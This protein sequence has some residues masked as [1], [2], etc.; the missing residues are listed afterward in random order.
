MEWRRLVVPSCF[1]ESEQR[2]VEGRRNQC[3]T[4]RYAEVCVSDTQGFRALFIILTKHVTIA[5]A[6]TQ[7]QHN[8][9][10]GGT[11]SSL[12]E[13]TDRQVPQNN[14]EAWR[15]NLKNNSVWFRVSVC[16][17]NRGLMLSYKVLPHPVIVFYMFTSRHILSYGF[18]SNRL[19]LKNWGLFSK[20]YLSLQDFLVPELVAWWQHRAELCMWPS[21]KWQFFG[22]YTVQIKELINKDGMVWLG[23][24]L[25]HPHCGV[26]MCS[27]CLHAFRTVSGRWPGP[28]DGWIW[29]LLYYLQIIHIRKENEIIAPQICVIQLDAQA[30]W[31]FSCSHKYKRK[32]KRKKMNI[33]CEIW[34]CF[35]KGMVSSRH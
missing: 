12:V 6:D 18:K 31:S 33:N 13:M 14:N 8:K 4:L 1:K 24:K 3:I 11:C 2:S 20:Q 22:F 5:S 16:M 25:C 29:I 10:R 21:I 30:H 17:R 19:N 23:V 27:L 35:K 26:W 28:M 32:K 34:Q 7:Q 9:D 15:A